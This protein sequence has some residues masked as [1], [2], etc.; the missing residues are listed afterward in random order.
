M[1]EIIM[2]TLLVR[3]SHLQE[4]TAVSGAH[5]LGLKARGQP[6]MPPLDKLC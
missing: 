5:L 2:R 4:S 3:L 6:K 1:C